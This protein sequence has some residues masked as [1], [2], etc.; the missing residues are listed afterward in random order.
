MEQIKY[1]TGSEEKLIQAGKKTCDRAFSSERI[2]YLDTLSK[3]IKMISAHAFIP[4]FLLSLF[5]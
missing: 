2:N 1:I 4:T 5:S 3:N